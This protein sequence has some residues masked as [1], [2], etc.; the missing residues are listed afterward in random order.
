MA[1]AYHAITRFVRDEKGQDLLEYA[2]LVALIAMA[3]LL[4][5]SSVGD[6]MNDMWWGPIA[7]AF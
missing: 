4:A 5:V 3:A 1:F 2:F 6:V 7:Q